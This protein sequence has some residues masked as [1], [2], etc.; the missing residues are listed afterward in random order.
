MDKENFFIKSQIQSNIDDVITLLNTGVFNVPVLSVFQEPVFVSI[1][2]K[3]D[4]LLQK[5]RI[6]GQR[7]CF[8]DD[9]IQGDITD[10]VNNIRN[11]V[12]HLNSAENILD[13]EAQI[14]FVFNVIIG[15]GSVI[16]IGDKEPAKNDYEDDVAFFYGENRIY[17]KRHLIRVVQEAEKI[18]KKLYPDELGK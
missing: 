2:L 3:L 15:K 16:A 9:I 6:L 12:C 7:I 14:K 1:I 5:F 11:A 13:K 8:Q 18:V 10:L 17:L 4:D